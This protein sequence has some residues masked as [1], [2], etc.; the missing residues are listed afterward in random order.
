MPTTTAALDWQLHPH[1][2]PLVGH[3]RR[4]SNRGGHAETPEPS[5]RAESC[6][7]RAVI[8]ELKS[9]LIPSPARLALGFVLDFLPLFVAGLQ[10]IGNPLLRFE[11]FLEQLRLRVNPVQK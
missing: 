2:V 4:P 9:L 7:R 11:P 8:C 3:A 1:F 5:A 6:R 10:R